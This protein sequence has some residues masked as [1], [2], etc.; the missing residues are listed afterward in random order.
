M[1]GG[2]APRTG[3]ANLLKIVVRRAYIQPLESSMGRRIQEPP[4]LQSTGEIA[5][6]CSFMSTDRVNYPDRA[7][8]VT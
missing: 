4:K 2:G 6:L 3:R 1:G 5:G 8:S 7:L